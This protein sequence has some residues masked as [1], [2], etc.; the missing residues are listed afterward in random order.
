M[1]LLISM[2]NIGKKYPMID[3]ERI[4]ELIPSRNTVR[5]DVANTSSEMVSKIKLDIRNAIEISAGFGVTTDFWTDD[6]KKYN[7]LSI[8]AHINL[9]TENAINMK[10]YILALKSVEAIKKTKEICLEEITS[11]FGN[12]DLPM[13]EVKNHVTFVTDRGSN[14]RAALKEFSRLNCYGYLN[15][16]IYCSNVQ[17]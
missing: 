16:N 5:K 17:S 14:L 2:V 9:F 3:N 8:T 15:N 13:D 12:Y 6:Q 1:D 7:Y 4:K 11:I 10:R